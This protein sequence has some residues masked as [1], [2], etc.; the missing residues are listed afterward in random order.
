MKF[1]MIVKASKESEAGVM[2]SE[3]L[4]SAMGKYNEELMKA[5]VLLDLSGLQP[6]S[7]GV[8]IKFSGGK[9]TVIDGP[10]TEAK[11]LIA[12]YWIIQVKSREEAMEWAKRIPAPQEGGDGEVEIRQFFE[13]DDFGPSEAIDRMREIEKDLEKKKE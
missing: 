3:Q 5:G 4:L 10:F 11:E 8:R 13:L 12:G 2:P 1:M 6:S 7:K 9:R